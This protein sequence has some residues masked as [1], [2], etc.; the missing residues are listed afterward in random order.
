MF[1][2]GGGGQTAVNSRQV[3]ELFVATQGSKQ[4]LHRVSR[5]VCVTEPAD[6]QHDNQEVGWGSW[7]EGVERFACAVMQV[8]GDLLFCL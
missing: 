6:T 1:F 4:L 5:E 8:E 7:G 2:F 3:S